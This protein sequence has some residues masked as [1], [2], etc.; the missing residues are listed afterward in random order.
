MAHTSKPGTRQLT[1]VAGVQSPPR[2]PALKKMVEHS[3]ISGSINI[4]DHDVKR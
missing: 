3:E 1:A 4:M 2:I